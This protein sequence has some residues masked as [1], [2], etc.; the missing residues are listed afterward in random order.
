MFIVAGGTIDGT[1][2]NL[3]SSTEIITYL[4]G[5]D[6]KWRPAFS[7]PKNMGLYNL[8]MINLNND[9]YLVGGITYNGALKKSVQINDI[10]EFKDG[11]WNNVGKMKTQRS[12]HAVSVVNYHDFCN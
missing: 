3:L 4:P 10:F 6:M 2:R 5:T 1:S 12:H 11:A 8:K 7:L 9:I